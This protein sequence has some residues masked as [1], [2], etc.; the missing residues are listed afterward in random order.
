MSKQTSKPPLMREQQRA[1]WAYNLARK[2][3]T[4][5]SEDVHT[6]FKI[7]ANRLGAHIMREGL[8]ST[9]AFLLRDG[10]GGHQAAVSALLQ[11]LSQADLP[12]LEKVKEGKKLPFE[13]LELDA[14]SYML[15]TREMLK[16]ALWLKRANQ[17][18][19]GDVDTID[20]GE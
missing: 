13:I 6:A 10:Q 16:L 17:A 1:L 9:L 2:I 20:I 11:A 15:V 19:L 5:H 14:V 7:T 3:K 4:E 18:V 8:A 12:C